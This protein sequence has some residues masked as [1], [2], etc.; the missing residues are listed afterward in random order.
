MPADES[1]KGISGNDDE[2]CCYLC[3]VCS[4]SFDSR[5]ELD[6]HMESHSMD[7]DD[8]D[9]ISNADST[10]APD[11][12]KQHFCR[13]CCKSFPSRSLLNVHYTHTHRDKPQYECD[14]CG[15]VF[16]IKRELA[17]HRRVHSGEPLHA[18]GICGKIFGTKQLL[19]KHYVWHTGNR[20]FVCPKCGKAFYQKGHLTQHMMIHTGGRPHVCQLCKKTFIF[21][22]DLNRHLK[23]HA[24]RGQSCMYCGDGFDD[25]EELQTHQEQCATINQ[26]IEEKNG[27]QF[28]HVP[29]AKAEVKIETPITSSCSNSFDPF[30]EIRLLASLSN[31]HSMTPK[32]ENVA[33]QTDCSP[34]VSDPPSFTPPEQRNS[35]SDGATTHPNAESSSSSNETSK[36]SS[37]HVGVR[38][39]SM[40]FRNDT[41]KFFIFSFRFNFI[42]LVGPTS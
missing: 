3:N 16:T 42:R 26:P 4:K 27:A 22:F 2:N 29:N 36:I 35:H 23:I 1:S 5:Q 14:F 28:D 30:A 10:E 8:L 34:S 11:S 32:S 31:Q 37:E 33:E 20:D 18:C 25:P 9:E 40:E 41:R 39:G 38:H 17:T 7:T 13:L 21:K 12:K 19:K 6:T 24:E 15:Q